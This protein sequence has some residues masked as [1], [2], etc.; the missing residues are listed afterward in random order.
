M[1]LIL[2]LGIIVDDAIVVG[3]ATATRYERW[4]RPH[5]AA[6]AAATR[7]VLPVIASTS[8]TQAAFLP[9]LLIGGVIGQILVAIPMVVV[10]ALLASLLECFLTLPSHLK[11][12]LAATQRARGRAASLRDASCSVPQMD[13]IAA[14]RGSAMALSLWLVASRIPLALCHAVAIDR[15]HDDGG[16]T[17]LRRSAAVHLL[18]GAGAGSGLRRRHVHTGPAGRASHRAWTGSRRPRARRRSR[19]A[20]T[21]RA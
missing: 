3:E 21:A 4:C 9:I 10:V 8:T 2:V 18:P 20:G 16:G 11:H 19:L 5:D 15:R 17:C 14:S 6:E 7:M 13:L 1:A 12:S